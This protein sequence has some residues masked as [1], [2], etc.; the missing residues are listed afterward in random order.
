MHRSQ[1]MK[2]LFR[3]KT[4][5]FVSLFIGACTGITTQHGYAPQPSELENIEVGV[6]T[7]I[8]VFSLIGTPTLVDE[9]YGTTWIYVENEIYAEGLK[10][11]VV[12]D[13]KI[14]LIAFDDG[15]IVT[16]V[17]TYGIKDG[18]PVQLTQQITETNKGRLTLVQQIMRS[19]GQIT[20]DLIAPDTGDSR[21]QF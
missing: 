3:L 10:P 12:T 7:Q 2:P 8:D 14:V 11:P 6:S 16:N 20:P 21:D 9:E 4:I 19:F 15:V 5:L 18:V 1:F 13:R 17:E